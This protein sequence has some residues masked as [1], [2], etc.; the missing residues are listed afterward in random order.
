MFKKMFVTLLSA[1]LLTVSV[2]S[3]LADKFPSKPIKI[4]VPFGAGGETDISAR[5]LAAAMEKELDN[6]VVVQNVTGASGMVGCKTVL[7]SHADGYTLGFIPSGPLALHPHMRKIPYTFDSFAYVGRAVNSAYFL[8][9]E[10]NSPWNTVPEMISDMKANPNKYFWASAGVGS[11]PYFSTG[12]VLKSFGVKAR[13]VAFKGD[14]DAFQAMA[15]NRVQLYATT[16]GVMG[17]FDIKPIAI[18]AEER[19][20]DLPNIPTVKE[21]GQDI[22]YSQW[23][24]LVAPKDVHPDVMAKLSNAMKAATESPE[25]IEKLAKLSLAPSYLNSTDTLEFVRTESAKNK[26]NI[27]AAMKKK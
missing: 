11:L 18:M 6:T 21:S 16:A 22:S 9:V 14:V 23:M 3:A 4:I 25:F 17:K 20:K 12:D 7:E 13:H 15:G 27:E 5:F 8:Y 10:K 2:G 24:V 19:Q 1:S 26:I